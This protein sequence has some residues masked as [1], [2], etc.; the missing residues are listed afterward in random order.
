MRVEDESCTPLK[1]R[2]RGGVRV[3]RSFAGGEQR[4]RVESHLKPVGGFSKL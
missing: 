1:Q 3:V 4:G 2:G